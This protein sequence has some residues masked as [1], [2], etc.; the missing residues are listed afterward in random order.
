MMSCG[1]KI[2]FVVR[3]PNGDEVGACRDHVGRIMQQ[4]LR[5]PPG[6][7]MPL[8]VSVQVFIPGEHSAGRDCTWSE[9]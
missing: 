8:G 3:Q 9:S 4:G 7:A 2:D 5:Q 1:K 6:E